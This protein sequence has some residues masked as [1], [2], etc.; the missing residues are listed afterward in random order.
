MQHLTDRHTVDLDATDRSQVRRPV[1]VVA[2]DGAQASVVVLAAGDPSGPGAV[3]EHR[4]RSWVI[5][6]RRTGSRVLMAT[7]DETSGH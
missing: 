7:P 5:R 4:G 2:D 1:I 3:F 6:G